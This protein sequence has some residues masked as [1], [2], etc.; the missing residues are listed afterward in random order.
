MRARR[1]RMTRVCVWV[2]VSAH[3]KIYIGTEPSIRRRL[4][5]TQLELVFTL[6]SSYV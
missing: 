3:V 4:S 5:H 1:H 2:Y 6:T